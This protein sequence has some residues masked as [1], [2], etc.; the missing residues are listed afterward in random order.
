MDVNFYSK[1]MFP[2]LGFIFV[3]D[4]RNLLQWEHLDRNM[5]WRKRKCLFT[6]PI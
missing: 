6:V 1:V 5:C 4:P 3:W 2:V